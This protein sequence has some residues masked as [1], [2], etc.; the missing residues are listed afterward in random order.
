MHASCNSC[1]LRAVRG[2]IAAHVRLQNIRKTFLQ[3]PFSCS[4]PRALRAFPLDLYMRS[5]VK[6]H[7][8]ERCCISRF[9][10]VPR[11]IFLTL[12]IRFGSKGFC[13]SC[14]LNQFYCPLVVTYISRMS[15]T[16]LGLLSLVATGP[17][18]HISV[19]P[20]RSWS[21]EASQSWKGGLDDRGDVFATTSDEASDAP[22]DFSMAFDI[23]NVINIVVAFV[24][25]AA[26]LQACSRANLKR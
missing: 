23:P 5:A 15:Y 26:Q 6:V 1:P 24:G 16:G 17:P 20:T 18:R 14:Y 4:V 9:P 19:S 2:P 22:V 8:S 13:D 21:S 11:I 7:A 25:S 3:S 10:Q 12:N